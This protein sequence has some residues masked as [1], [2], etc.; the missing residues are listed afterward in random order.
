MV[1]AAAILDVQKA[2]AVRPGEVSW[3]AEG[4]A[5]LRAIGALCPDE[6]LRNPDYLAEKFVS[7]E[8]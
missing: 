6:K 8:C 7:D 3:T 5:A 4:V 1:G 2:D